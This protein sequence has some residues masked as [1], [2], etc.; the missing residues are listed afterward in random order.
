M[1]AG[2]VTDYPH[3]NPPRGALLGVGGGGGGAVRPARP[4]RR[5]RLHD[6]SPGHQPQSHTEL[7]AGNSV[8]ISF[9]YDQSNNNNNYINQNDNRNTIIQKATTLFHY[10]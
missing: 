8:G 3:Y 10:F 5:P 2:P 4:R 7:G 6:V 1:Q 9:Q